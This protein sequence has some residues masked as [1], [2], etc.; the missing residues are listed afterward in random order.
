VNKK[1]KQIFVNKQ[2]YYPLGSTFSLN[3]KVVHIWQIDMKLISNDN[4]LL[5]S[6]LLSK[7]EMERA[8]K[9]KFDSDRE[10]FIKGTG[11]LR[12]LI[13]S[14]AGIPAYDI[15]FS[16]NKYGK[17]EILN[18]QNN[19]K[20]N[21]NLSNSQNWLCIGFILN[22]SIGVDLEIIKPINDFYDV[23]DKFFSDSEIKQLKTFSEKESLQAFYACWTGKEAFIKFSG[24]GLSYPLKQFEVKIKVLDIEKNFQYTLL[25]KNTKEKFFVEAF[26]LNEKSV[27][28]FALKE[29][30]SETIYQ[31]FE[32]KDYSINMFIEDAVKE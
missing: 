4:Q 28:A 2:I 29:K 3:E 23:A 30:P 12:L 9:F 27:G 20:L 32:Q 10:F 13:Q 16:Q 25:T 26:R 18:G 15:S 6:G 17:P 22:E 21:F 7:D 24:E 14:Y 31:I 8:S 11:L 19:T 5:L 1:W